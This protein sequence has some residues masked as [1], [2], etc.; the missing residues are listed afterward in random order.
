[1]SQSDKL[2]LPWHNGAGTVIYNS[3]DSTVANVSSHEYAR[4]IVAC[5]HA[6]TG[7]DTKLLEEFPGA[8]NGMSV[9]GIAKQRDLYKGQCDELL[10]AL[11]W[12]VANHWAHPSNLVGVAKEAIAKHRGSI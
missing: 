12:I 11:E 2:R 1:M 10:S 6:C 3:D 8:M 4:R 5:V 9:I 7:A